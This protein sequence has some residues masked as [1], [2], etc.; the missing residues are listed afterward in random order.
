MARGAA[1]AQQCPRHLAGARLP[2]TCAGGVADAMIE[3]REAKTLRRGEQ[4]GY[5]PVGL[6]SERLAGLSPAPLTT[7]RAPHGI[8]KHMQSVAPKD[9]PRYR[10]P[11]HRRTTSS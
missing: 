2:R 7:R 3:A 4:A 11:K 10:R 8:D 5:A 9:T 1:K 6:V